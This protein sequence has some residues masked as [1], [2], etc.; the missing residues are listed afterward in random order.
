MDDAEDRYFLLPGEW[1]P[2]VVRDFSGERERHEEWLYHRMRWLLDNLEAIEQAAG[3]VAPNPAD[4]RRRD[5]ARY[6]RDEPVPVWARLVRSKSD[7]PSRIFA[8]ELGAGGVDLPTRRIKD[9]LPVIPPSRA[10]GSTDLQTKKPTNRAIARAREFTGRALD[11]WGAEYERFE[12]S[13]PPKPRAWVKPRPKRRLVFPSEV[14]ANGWHLALEKDEL[15]WFMAGFI[16]GS[17]DELANRQ[18]SRLFGFTPHVNGLQVARYAGRNVEE[19]AP[20]AL[21]RQFINEISWLP[22]VN[23]GDDPQGREL[24]VFAFR[25]QDERSEPRQ[26]EVFVVITDQ[27]VLVHRLIL[28]CAACDE[29]SFSTRL[30]RALGRRKCDKCGQEKLLPEGWERDPDAKSGYPISNVRS[31]A[32]GQGRVEI[33]LLGPSLKYSGA[34]SQ[35]TAPN[36]RADVEFTALGEYGRPKGQ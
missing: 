27:R 6:Y 12:A 15:A 22:N 4:D 23:W 28:A 11:E 14:W 20:L 30:V 10:R 35:L 7:L 24:P 29:P 34:D 18:R 26:S 32:V 13:P 17:H 5:F 2:T 8:L 33:Q 19:P 25:G 21:A 16:F 1:E 36:S 31:V 9:L 3:R